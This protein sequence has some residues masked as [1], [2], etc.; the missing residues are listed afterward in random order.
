MLLRVQRLQPLLE[1]ILS[2]AACLPIRAT[3]KHQL[4]QEEQ[5]NTTL[6]SKLR[7]RLFLDR[8]VW[9]PSQLREAACNGDIVQMNMP[10]R[11]TDANEPAVD[12]YVSVRPD[13]TWQFDA[14]VERNMD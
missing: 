12:G 4:G 11:F 13:T 6:E 2:F 7:E 14:M 9:R 10:L 1:H 5:L 3:S 8:P